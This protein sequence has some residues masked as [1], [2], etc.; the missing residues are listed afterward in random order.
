MFDICHNKERRNRGEEGK[1]RD[2]LFESQEHINPYFSII[3]FYYYPCK[4]K[5][6]ALNTAVILHDKNEALGQYMANTEN[7][8]IG[9]H[10]QIHFKYLKL[11]LIFPNT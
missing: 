1:K 8:Q 11:C 7:G 3:T 2:F 5:S 4:C 6:A 9:F 10:W